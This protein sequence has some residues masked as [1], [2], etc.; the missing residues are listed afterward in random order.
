MNYDTISLRHIDAGTLK[1]IACITMFIDHLAIVFLDIPMPDGCCLRELLPHGDQLLGLGS[2]IGR[3]A[4]PI[5]AFLLVEG[6]VY[7]RSRGRYLLRLVLLAAV[8]QVFFALAFQSYDPGLYLNTVFTLAFGLMLTWLL[9][10]VLVR[11]LEQ[12]TQASGRRHVISIVIRALICVGAVAGVCVLSMG[13]L[14]CDYGAPGILAILAFYLLRT[15][16]PLQVLAGYGVLCIAYRQEIGAWPAAILL[17][18]YNGQ[19]GRQ[20]K[21]FFYLFYPGH[22]LFLYLLRTFTLGY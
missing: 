22:L 11:Y 14:P 1:I 8:S 6:Y 7:T 19:R 20:L 4:F 16:R 3:Q 13:P 18:C 21:W 15:V 5:Y 17:L 10:T 2:Y 12:E 9:D